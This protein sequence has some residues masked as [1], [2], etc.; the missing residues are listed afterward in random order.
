MQQ[1]SVKGLGVTPALFTFQ[2]APSFLLLPSLMLRPKTRDLLVFYHGNTL[3]S[4]PLFLFVEV[5][6][7]FVVGLK[8]KMLLPMPSESR[9]LGEQTPCLFL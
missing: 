5:R 3:Y 4:Q 6:P 9:D 2:L 1:Y 7:L 8:L